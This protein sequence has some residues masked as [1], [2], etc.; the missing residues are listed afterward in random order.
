MGGRHESLPS[1]GPRQRRVP[2]AGHDDGVLDLG[3]E[4]PPY[5]FAGSP[6]SVLPSGRVTA[7]YQP[8]GAPSRRGL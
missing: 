3:R 1:G 4:S 2:G 7:R 6:P 5:G 8:P